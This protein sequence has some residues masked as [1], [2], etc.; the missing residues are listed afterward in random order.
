MKTPTLDGAGHD[1]AKK[2]V[3]L[4]LPLSITGAAIFALASL[5]FGNENWMSI[6]S[7]TLI[8]A[9]ILNLFTVVTELTM[10]HPSTAAHTVVKMITKGRYKGLFWI[11]VILIGNLIPLAALLVVPS[12]N[13]LIVASVLVLI[14]IYV[15]EK[16]WVEAP[17]RIP[18]A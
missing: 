11:G 17:Q 1:M 3:A 18:L 12:A 4:D 5:I 10:T 9:L 2:G 13:M 14:G 6:I 8:V 16:I 15:T 7:L